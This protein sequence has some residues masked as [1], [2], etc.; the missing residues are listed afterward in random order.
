VLDEAW[1]E[2]DSARRTNKPS[3]NLPIKAR[4]STSPLDEARKPARRLDVI[5][6]FAITFANNVIF[7][8]YKQQLSIDTSITEL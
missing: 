3:L 7:H 4:G 6:K 2:L 5:K 8:S 1:L